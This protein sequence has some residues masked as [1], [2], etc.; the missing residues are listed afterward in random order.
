VIKEDLQGASFLRRSSENISLRNPGDIG[1]GLMRT[2]REKRGTQDQIPNRRRNEA[3][4]PAQQ[5]S[6]GEL[7]ISARENPARLRE[8]R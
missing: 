7:R 1:K 3:R 6:A 4:K 5:I 8:V 2:A